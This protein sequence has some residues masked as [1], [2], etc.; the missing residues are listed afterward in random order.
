M[1][2]LNAKVATMYIEINTL[3]KDHFNFRNF[4]SDLTQFFGWPCATIPFSSVFKA[5]NLLQSFFPLK[6]IIFYICQYL[7]GIL[8]KYAVLM[9]KIRRY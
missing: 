6:F 8:L 7:L 4:V 1:K 9:K 5:K 2:W 3:F